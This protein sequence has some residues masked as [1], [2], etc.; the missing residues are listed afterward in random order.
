MRSPSWP[1]GANSGRVTASMPVEASATS[2]TVN[3]TVPESRKVNPAAPSGKCSSWVGTGSQMA[4]TR[5][6]NTILTVIPT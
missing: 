5:P 6:S 4:N 2:T 3:S 1:E